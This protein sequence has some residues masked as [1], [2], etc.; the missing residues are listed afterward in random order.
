MNR[1]LF[2]F[3]GGLMLAAG[4][5]QGNVPP[6]EAGDKTVIGYWRFDGDAPL[7]DL[8]SGAILTLPQT[9]VG[10]VATGGFQGGALQ[11]TTGGAQA[12]GTLRTARDTYF[13]YAVRVKKS[14]G[15]SNLPE[16]SQ[17]SKKDE[18]MFTHAFNDAEHWHMVAARYQSG[19]TGS[20]CSYAVF[21]DMTD[22]NASPRPEIAGD[23]ITMPISANGTTVKLGGNVYSSSYAFSGQVDEA[24]IIN[25]MMTKNEIVRLLQTG[26][27]Y[28]W[29]VASDAKGLSSGFVDGN[30]WSSKENTYL[31]A[32]GE[33]SGAAYIVDGNRTL[34]CMGNYASSTEAASGAPYTAKF[35]GANYDKISLT[36]GRTVSLTNL[37]EPT[38]DP[39]IAVSDDTAN[40]SRMYIY[41]GA[42]TDV[43]IN[44]LRLNQGVIGFAS[45][46][47]VF[48]ANITVNAS[49]SSPFAL[50][51]NSGQ[52]CTLFGTVSGDGYL[53]KQGTGNMDLTGL[54][55]DFRLI[56]AD[57]VKSGNVKT[58]QLYSYASGMVI[59]D[60]VGPVVFKDD[61]EIVAGSQ[62][63][64]VN[65][66]FATRPPR[67]RYH[68]LT[69]PAAYG[70]QQ[71]GLPCTILDENVSVSANIVQEGREV[72]AEFPVGDF[73]PVP[74][75][76]GE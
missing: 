69:L 57:N 40:D 73:G 16:P 28:I 61:G 33:I 72:Y 26:E 45:P 36:I 39:I 49:K 38:A 34:A 47:M 64:R 24:M 11:I 60:T 18:K 76:I 14:S 35:G 27:T 70:S 4:P 5:A 75:V 67:G 56:M 59:V 58:K 37:L 31:P 52:S 1:R 55:G 20:S 17:S 22:P 71:V 50:S 13:T 41:G 6:N 46:E 42:G 30:G 43:T 29:L 7:V 9:G 32:P 48:R 53:K 62:G 8:M 23:S 25:R 2:I 66:A 15:M 74:L 65:I 12:T 21:C 10:T 19:R 63:T 44:D 54:T 51:N 68:I 3:F